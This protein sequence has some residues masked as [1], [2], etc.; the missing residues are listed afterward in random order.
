MQRKAFA[1]RNGAF[2]LVELLVVIGI[3]AVLI[4]ILLP[5]LSRA[6][7]QAKVVACAS[8]IRQIV[9]ASLS[10]ANDNKGYLPPRWGGGIEPMSALGNNAEYEYNYLT[11]SPA[12]GAAN[13]LPSNIGSLMV[14]GYLGNPL[15]TTWLN[16]TNSVTGYPQYASLN[17][18]PVRFD[19][20]VDPQSMSVAIDSGSLTPQAGYCWSSSYLFNPHWAFT[21]SVGTWPVGGT[22]EQYSTVSQ[23]N[24]VNGFSQYR[25]LVSDMIYGDMTVAHRSTNYYSWNL[26]FIDGHVSTVQD[27]FLWAVANSPSTALARWPSGSGAPLES[28]EDDLDILETEA[29]GKNTAL[30]TADPNDKLFTATAS[31]YIRRLEGNN[32]A[33]PGDGSYPADSDHP[34]VG[35]R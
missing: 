13:S 25:S 16:Q 33:A 1:K 28:V 19:P 35:W 29:G 17:V 4:S 22:A 18:V 27:T 24:K 23:F 10:Y 32:S 34:L 20:A 9:M 31:G 5:A 14:Y 30:V 6:R 15:D 26:G 11:Y 21:S 8:N 2:T 7:Q 12:S 3:I